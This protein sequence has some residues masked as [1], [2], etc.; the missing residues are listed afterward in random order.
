MWS[1]A[2]CTLGVAKPIWGCTCLNFRQG[3][4]AVI[5]IYQNPPPKRTSLSQLIKCSCVYLCLSYY[6]NTTLYNYNSHICS[7]IFVLLLL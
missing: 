5:Y 7:F 2:L 3:L 4:A 6:T 1:A